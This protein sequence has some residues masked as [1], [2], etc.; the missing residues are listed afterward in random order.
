MKK[1]YNKI[2]DSRLPNILSLMQNNDKHNLDKVLK[3]L[4]VYEKKPEEKN[5]LE[6]ISEEKKGKK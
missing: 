1:E 3:A 4:Q 6:K 5:I 2:M